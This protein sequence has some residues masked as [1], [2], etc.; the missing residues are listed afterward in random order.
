MCGGRR[1]SPI[2]VIRDGGMSV[3]V[4][5][6]LRAILFTEARPM[7]TCVYDAA[8]YYSKDH[9][10]SSSGQ[11]LQCPLTHHPTIPLTDS[12]SH[13]RHLF[14]SYQSQFIDHL[15]CQAP[16]SLGP[17]IAGRHPIR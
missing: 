12:M 14:P 7:A 5:P 13:T 3:A 4:W 11:S 15:L 16:L 6:I 1:K 17:I 9:D 2:C 8:I 10:R